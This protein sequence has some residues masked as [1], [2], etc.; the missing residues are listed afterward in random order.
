MGRNSRQK[1][2]FPSVSPRSDGGNGSR[3]ERIMWT[4][5]R[6]GGQ[7]DTGE[8]PLGFGRLGRQV[9]EGTVSGKALAV[10]KENGRDWPRKR[11]GEQEQ[12]ACSL[13]APGGYCEDSKA[14]EVEM[15]KEEDLDHRVP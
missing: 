12:A 13:G 1:K 11:L 7:G 2:H 8:G 10:L 9:R 4:S 5:V 15:G 6:S 3:Q 14:R